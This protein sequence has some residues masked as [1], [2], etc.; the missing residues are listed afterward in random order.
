MSREFSNRYVPF[1]VSENVRAFVREHDGTAGYPNMGV[2]V[3]VRRRHSRSKRYNHQASAL[4]AIT[5][6]ILLIALWGLYSGLLSTSGIEVAVG[7]S[8]AASV[9][10]DSAARGKH[11]SQA[12]LPDREMSAKRNIIF[13]P[14]F[15][16][17]DDPIANW[18]ELY[19]REAKRFLVAYEEKFSFRI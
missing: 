13:R 17:L 2:P 12:T 7:D 10:S 11:D 6:P 19:K 1:R 8:Y 3:R 18:F 14:D 5:I 16:T 4:K 15:P 9:L